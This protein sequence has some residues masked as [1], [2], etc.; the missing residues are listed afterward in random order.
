MVMKLLQHGI[1]AATFV[2]ALAAGVACNRSGDKDGTIVRSLDDRSGAPSTPPDGD[3]VGVA[4][5]T[6]A[7]IGGLSSDL[8]VQRIVAARCARQSS[9]E[10]A[11]PDRRLTDP[12]VCTQRLSER[13]GMDLR[14]NDCPRGIDSAALDT[15]LAAIGNES[16]GSPADTMRRIG[17]CRTKELCLKISDGR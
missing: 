8:A 7:E 14:P 1:V 2:S 9:C 15:C 4:T 5:V 16:C 3:R 17:S 10:T 6:G 11:G 13:L 12:A